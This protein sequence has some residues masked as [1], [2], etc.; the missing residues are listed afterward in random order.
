ME[1]TSAYIE[2]KPWGVDP[3]SADPLILPLALA[4]GPSRFPVAAMTRHL[5]TNISIISHFVDRSITC[6][7]EE[8]KPG[9]VRVD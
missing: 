3:H 2:T 5:L 6:A 4:E 8:G 7:G 1:Q 9:W